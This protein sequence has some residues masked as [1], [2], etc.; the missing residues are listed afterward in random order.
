[1]STNGFG[2]RLWING[3]PFH[4]PGLSAVALFATYS[5]GPGESKPQTFPLAPISSG[6]STLHY[7]VQVDEFFVRR[8][9]GGRID[10]FVSVGLGA[11]RYG[12]DDDVPIVGGSSET[13][14][15]L[16]P[17]AG[18]RLPFPNRFEA[19]LDVRDLI[20]LTGMTNVDGSQKTTHNPVVQAGFG[21]TF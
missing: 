11:F 7:G 8:P 5:P 15:A 17:G 20:I 12:F 21:L 14:V 16:S 3:A 19:R 6:F 1:V 4:F 2:A 9:I 10:P 18:I 13:H